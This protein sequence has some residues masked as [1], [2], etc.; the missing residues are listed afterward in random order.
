MRCFVQAFADA[1]RIAEIRRFG[2]YFMVIP[3]DDS[4]ISDVI[5]D[6]DWVRE[7]NAKAGGYYVL[8]DNGISEYMDKDE[9]DMRSTLLE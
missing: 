9:F 3:E 5:V 2:D 7:N 1:F 8:F 4:L 6:E